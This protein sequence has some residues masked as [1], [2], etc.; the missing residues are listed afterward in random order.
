MY[1]W[2]RKEIAEAFDVSRATPHYWIHNYG[3]DSNHPF[4]EPVARLQVGSAGTTNWG[5]HQF[6]YDPGE[7]QQWFAGLADAKAERMSIAQS[8]P[9]RKNRTP[10]RVDNLQIAVE[11]V[12][13]L[14]SA[15]A[16]L[17]A[18]RIE[19]V[20]LQEEVGALASLQRNT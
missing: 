19:L 6:V 5:M 1:V 16:V 7:V 20:A 12:A 13:E 8:V 3:P 14:R 11:A 2:T 15:M 18:T 9:N 10:A 17:V 4:P